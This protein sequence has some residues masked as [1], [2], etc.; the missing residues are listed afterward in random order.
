[1]QCA[2]ARI[3]TSLSVVSTVINSHRGGPHLWGLLLYQCVGSLW[4]SLLQLV[5]GP[6]VNQVV[7]TVVKPA[8]ELPM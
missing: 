6:G 7:A 1:M 2:K 5:M 8:S 3:S 4:I